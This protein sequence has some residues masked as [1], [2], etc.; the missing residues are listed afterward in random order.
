M[1]IVPGLHQLKT[2]FPAPALPYIIPY[3]L[4]GPDGVSLIDAGFG[5]PAATASMTAQLAAL[6]FEPR[7]IR[8]LF[9]THAH[10]DHMGM[11]SWVKEQAPDAEVIMLEREWQ[12]IQDRWLDIEE[13]ARL[14]D[15][16]LVRH[17]LPQEEV[18]TA[19]AAGALAPN[20]PAVRP[21]EA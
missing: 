4:V 3:A 11:A 12:W 1:E 5:T 8:R 13:W 16:W 15:V 19:R 18:D 10:P 14:S 9:I 21:G 6:G 7:Q 17:G 20:A 2:P